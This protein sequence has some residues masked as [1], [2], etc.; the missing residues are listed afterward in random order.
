MTARRAGQ[1]ARIEPAARRLDGEPI[2][3]TA[4]RGY[5]TIHRIW[6][7]G[8]ALTLD[9]NTA[10]ERLYAHPSVRMDVGRTALR[11]GPWIYCVEEVDNPG[12]PVQALTLPRSAQLD[13]EW[14]ADLFGG[15]VTLK[16]NAKRLVPGNASGALYSTEPPA[17]HDAY[18]TALPYHLWANRAPGSMQ[19]WWLSLRAS[20]SAYKAFGARGRRTKW[21]MTMRKTIL[22]SIAVALMLAVASPPVSAQSNPPPGA[23]SAGAI[24]G[25]GAGAGSNAARTRHRNT[26]NRQRARATSDHARHARKSSHH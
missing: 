20:A 22:A 8:A 11:C 9:L 14:R 1:R 7:K 3:L 4:I 24:L 13:A 21:D 17:A 19:V 12:G 18:L 25:T 10:A 15:A 23:A 26:L 5:A 2:A 16:A 6:R